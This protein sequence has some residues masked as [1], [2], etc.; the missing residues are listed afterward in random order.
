VSEAG[1]LLELFKAS[2]VTTLDIDDDR[3][4]VYVPRKG[5]GVFRHDGFSEKMQRQD[6]VYWERELLDHPNVVTIQDIN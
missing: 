2:G 5:W 3:T 1:V 6:Y 4:R